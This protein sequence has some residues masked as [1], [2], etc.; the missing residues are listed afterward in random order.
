MGKNDEFLKRLLATF[1]VEAAEHITAISSGL[2]ELE[3]SLPPERQAEIIEAVFRESHSMKGAARAVNQSVIESVCQSFE[4]VLSA[5]KRR[6][7]VPSRDLLDLLHR[8][9]NV[10]EAVLSKGAGSKV[11]IRDLI[12]ELDKASTGSGLGEATK[13]A[14]IKSADVLFPVSDQTQPSEELAA[15]VPGGTAETIRI[16]KQRLDSIL[17]QAEGLLSAKQLMAQ[18]TAELHEVIAKLAVLKK[19]WVKIRPVMRRIG[20]AAGKNDG[21]ALVKKMLDF[22]DTQGEHIA[23]LHG[24]IAAIGKASEH[25]NRS[26][27]AMADGL[28]DD[29]KSVSMLPFSSILEMMPKV[30]RDLA[31]DRG[32]DAS[33]L[34]RGGEI[35]IDRR[36]LDEMRDPLIHL[37]RNCIDHGIEAPRE[38]TAADKPPAGTISIN[39]AHREGK[40]VE[41][42]VSDDG[43]GVD[44]SK[45]VTS[46]MR[47]G[48]FSPEEADELDEARLLSH[49]FRSGVTTS[50]MITDISGR[51]LGLAIVQEKVERL[52][53]SVFCE[54]Y[55]G[56]GTTFRIFL[57]LALATFRGML[58]LIDGRRFII[59]ITGIDCT[60]RVGRNKIKT[61]ENRE[62][63]NVGDRTIPFVPLRAVL[64]MP[65]K[66]KRGAAPEFV[67]AAVLGAGE[68]RIAFGVDDIVNEQEVLVKDLGK[69][70]ARV[71]NVAG[72]TVLGSGE[73]VLVL[74]VSDLLK[75]A[76]RGAAGAEPRLVPVETQVKKKSVLVVEDSITARTLV[77]NILEGAGY[78]V[79]TAVDGVDAL[80][81][82]RTESFDVVVSDVD[83][84][85]MNGLDLT[86]RIRADRK[87]AYLPVILVT[88]LESRED[89][90]RGIDVGA[91][92][93][94]IKSSFDQ[95][96]LLEAIKRLV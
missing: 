79:R 46:A 11:V 70:L 61:V 10:I 74:S 54:T 83:M 22:L 14:E 78:D 9:V 7:I 28:L 87:V 2:I 41:I 88:A 59:P 82:I 52:G 33:L 17:L 30:V 27:A 60:V 36:I 66:E 35:E 86:A 75:S 63:I 13:S 95:S 8:S 81:L 69:Q 53:G 64:E 32:K 93:Y 25:D 31:H 84:P 23:K 49:I 45:I 39:V 77:K 58:V 62:T 37:V 94:I 16:S 40:A 76:V 3:K 34:T 73:V 92:A 21:G 85:R 12:S 29:L 91:S 6:E 90:E 51:G 44:T 26:V 24:S 4:G 50:P 43:A 89:R 72:A 38:R 67:E 5:L 68:Q 71:R 18:R 48:L 42:T 57:P 19:E 47:L 80:T 15:P 96:N 55:R 20:V 65:L 56:K 1:M